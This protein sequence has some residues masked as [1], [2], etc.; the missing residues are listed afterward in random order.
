MTHQQLK[1]IAD[2][3]FDGLIAADLSA[4]PYHDQ[5]ILRTPLADGGSDCP[6]VG[7]EAVLGFFSG[8]Y[9]ALESVSIIAYFFNEDATALSVQAHIVLKS[10]KSLRVMDLFVVDSNGQV[11]EQE[12]HYD[13]RPALG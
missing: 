1:S 4:L 6:I 5:V 10:G 13:P 2:A 7:K 9:A 8:I 3:Y 12:N 11:T